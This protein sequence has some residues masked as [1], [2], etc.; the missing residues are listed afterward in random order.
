MT[1]DPSAVHRGWMAVVLALAC[2]ACATPTAPEPVVPASPPPKQSATPAVAARPP[3]L[4]S[5][6][7]REPAAATREKSRAE[8][9]FERGV[10]SY[11]DGD[12]KSAERQLKS[13]LSLGLPAFPDQAIAHKYLAFIACA[14]GLQRSCRDEFRKALEADGNFNLAPAESGH[15]VWGPVFRSVKAEMAKPRSK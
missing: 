6:A 8:L 4:R 9:D 14:S 3:D 11:E 13:A 5:A 2:S 12:Y 1:I 10:K 7:P 15:P